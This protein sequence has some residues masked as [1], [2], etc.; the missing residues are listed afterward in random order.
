MKKIYQHLLKAVLILFLS[1][2][3]FLALGFFAV[4]WGLTNVA[5]EEDGNSFAYNQIAQESPLTFINPGLPANPSIYGENEN[6]NWCLLG[7]AAE[8]S[9]HEAKD[10]LSAYLNTKSEELLQRMLLALELRKGSNSEFSDSLASCNNE[11][12]RWNKDS[13]ISYL[14][15]KNETS[16]Y[17]WQDTEY[18]QIIKEAIVKDEKKIKQA[19]SIAGIQPRLLVSVAIVEQLRLYYTQREFYEQFFKPLKILANANKMAWGVM[20]IKEKMAI[21]TE[22][23]LR[24][25]ASPFYLGKDKEKLLDFPTDIDVNKER[26]LRLT[27]SRNHYY[28]YLYGALI[29]KELQAQWQG[30]GYNI[31]YRPEIIATLYNIGFDHS[32]PKANPAVGGSTLEINGEKYFFGSLAFEFYYSGELTTE[33]PFE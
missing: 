8:T 15:D 20:S 27:D 28:S 12:G 6:L 30:A 5:G 19:A 14:A 7:V 24:D 32:Q 10:M 11:I 25:Q 16:A 4:R 21:Q 17:T 26:Y 29:I 13:L 2:I 33:F 23:H 9:P 3:F 31:D 18:W 1:A 22:E